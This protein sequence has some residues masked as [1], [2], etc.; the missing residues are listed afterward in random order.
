MTLQKWTRTVDSELDMGIRYYTLLSIFNNLQLTPRQIELLSFTSKR[1]TISSS[2][3]KGE[4]CRK[5]HTTVSTVNNMISV[6]T[7]RNYLVRSDGKIIVNPGIDV[8]FTR[9]IIINLHLRSGPA[10]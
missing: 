2:T 8:N 3:A 4:F 9:D 7:S 5:F 1:G 6:L 10:Q